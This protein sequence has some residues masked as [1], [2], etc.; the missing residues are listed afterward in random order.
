MRILLGEISSYKAIVIARHIREVYPNVEIW[1]YDSKPLLS[2]IHTKYIDQYIALKNCGHDKDAYV[3]QLVACLR[4][5]HADVLIPVH[6]DYIGEILLHKADF[7]HALDYMGRYE[8]YLQLHEKDRLMALAKELGI[9]IPV[10][11]TSAEDAKVPFVVKPTALSSSKGVRYCMQEEVR[12]AFIPMDAHTICQEYIE[13]Q[14]CGYSVY[15]REG[16]I[17]S[18]YGHLRLAEW[19]ISGGSSV[20]RKGFFHPGMREAAEK[21]LARVPWTGYAMFEFKLTPAGDVVLIEVNPRIWGS[22]H[23]ALAGGTLLFKDVFH[24][25]NSH[26]PASNLDI[27]TCLWPQ[28]L[29]SALGY[30]IRKGQWSV[31]KEYFSHDV[32]K[33][34][35]FISDLGGFASMLIRKIL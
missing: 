18:E 34:V 7:G 12:M 2:R 24:E 16:K 17:L 14:G 32:K 21:I 29:L 26:S 33:D 27:R 22:I 28:V 19:P 3:S 23:Q 13:G 25:N 6:S 15:C 9:R 11:Y 8:D 10:N 35:S 4:E 31:M 20:Y 5:N 1:A 30:G